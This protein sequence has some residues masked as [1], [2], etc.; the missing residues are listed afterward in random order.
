MRNCWR[1]ASASFCSRSSRRATRTSGWPCSAY[2]RANSSPKPLDAPVI[3]THELSLVVI[4]LARGRQWIGL[5]G[6]RLQRDEREIAVNL[7]RYSPENLR[8][9]YCSTV[10]SVIWDT[11][12]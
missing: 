6:N 5:Y 8:L 4:L 3:R 11:S 2:W 9:G 1:S 12:Q 10:H 7:G